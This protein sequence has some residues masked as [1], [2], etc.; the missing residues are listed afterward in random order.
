MTDDPSRDK[1]FW[2]T[3][4]LDAMTR[5]EW[6]SLCDGCGLCCLHK[7]EDVDT[8]EVA[9]TDIA[10]RLLDCQSCRCA[11]YPN[12]KRHVPD[13][14]RLTPETLP[15]IYW[16]PR[17]CGYRRVAEGRGLAWWHPLV[18][19]DPE[20]VHEAGISARGR[21]VSE[22]AIDDAETHVEQWLNAGGEPLV[23]IPPRR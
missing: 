8:G 17:S 5:A 2:E 1:P 20:T 4:R 22:A 10:C 23:R 3:K 19:G 7:L 14:V 16:L 13:C 18:S 6:E 11:D 15:E 9:F 21:V 12:R